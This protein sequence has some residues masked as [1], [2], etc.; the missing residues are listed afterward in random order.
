MLLQEFRGT[1]YCPSA[2]ILSLRL[3]ISDNSLTIRVVRRSCSSDGFRFCCYYWFFWSHPSDSNRRPAD[4]EF[5]V[6][7]IHDIP[8][9]QVISILKGVSVHPKPLSF[10]DDRYSLLSVVGIILGCARKAWGRRMYERCNLKPSAGT[11]QRVS[12]ARKGWP[13]IRKRV[14]RGGGAIHSAKRRQRVCG[15]CD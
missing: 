6:A 9:Q 3:T 2:A 14:L 4:Y 12:S 11:Q 10:N 8:Q 7:R 13:A 5:W 15:P 1:N